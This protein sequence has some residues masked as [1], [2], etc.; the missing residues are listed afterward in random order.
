MPNQIAWWS[1]G[2]GPRVGVSGRM[3]LGMASRQARWASARGTA[4]APSAMHS[5][6]AGLTDHRSADARRPR[7]RRAPPR[8]APASTRHDHPRRR[9]AER[10][11]GRG[12]RPGAGRGGEVDAEADLAGERHLA[13]RDREAAVAHVVHA[14][15][16]A[17]AHQVGDERRAAAPRASRSAAGGSAAVETVHDRGPLRTAELGADL[18]EHDD[19]RRRRAS[20]GRGS[21]PSQLVDRAEHADDRRGVDVG[22][23]RRVVEARR[24]RRSPGCRAPRTPRSCPRRPRRTATSPRGARGCRS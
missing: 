10:R 13:Q 7:P 3:R 1:S 6:A 21:G 18:A 24:C 20:R 16:R 5:V 11:L 17:V 19:R 23:A 4:K 14:G 22:A 12:A 2:F 9:L 8:P 15:D